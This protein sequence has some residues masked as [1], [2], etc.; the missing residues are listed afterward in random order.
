MTD[1]VDIVVNCTGLGAKDLGGVA[2]QKMSPTRGQ[3]VVVRA[4]HIRKTVSIIS[5]F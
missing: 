4:Q 5:K 1:D 3:N 2:D